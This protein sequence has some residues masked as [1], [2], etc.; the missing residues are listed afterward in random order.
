MSYSRNIRKASIGKRVLISWAVIAGVTFVIAFACGFAVRSATT[1]ADT[2]EETET[3]EITTYGTI[4]GRTFSG[5]EMSLD[6]GDDLEFTPLDV[7]LDE[8]IQEFVF[9]LSYGY[10]IDWTFTMA[11]IQKESSY[12]ADA[13]SCCN[14]YGLMQIN[15]INHE[16]ITE[17]LGV[18]DYLNPYE[19]VRAG[20]WILRNLFEKYESPEKVLMAYNMGE[21]GASILWEQG[22]FETNYSKSVLEIQDELNA[23]LEGSE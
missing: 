12:Q 20:L 16:Y 21:T 4:D 9:Y 18:T 19:N 2:P 6:W 14:D 13:I 3:A 5:S 17:T 15:E 22:I 7:P 23:Q 10:N 11:V 8:G 1:K